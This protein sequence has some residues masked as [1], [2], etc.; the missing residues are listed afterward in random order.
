MLDRVAYD[1]RDRH[2][3]APGFTNQSC[4]GIVGKHD[5]CP[6]H[7]ATVPHQQEV[8]GETGKPVAK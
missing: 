1:L 2:P 5:R 8:A 6:L 7:E 3:P 4:V